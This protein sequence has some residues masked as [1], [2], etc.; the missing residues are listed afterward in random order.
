MWKQL[1]PLK[2]A[3]LAVVILSALFLPAAAEKVEYAVNVHDSGLLK[4]D[5]K[6]VFVGE[7][8]HIIKITNPTNRGATGV[9]LYVPIV[10]NE[11][12]RHYTILYSVKPTSEYT[13][14]V[15]GS[16]NIY[17]CWTNLMI[18]PRQTFTVELNY[19]LLSFSLTYTV[20]SNRIGSYNKNSELYI[21]Y[22]QPEE[23]IQSSHEEIVEKAQEITQG[24]EDP[25]M[26]A[27][28]IYNFVVS[29][30]RYEIQEEEKGALW[31]LENGKGDCS[32]YS[33]L[34]VALCRAAG[35][36]ARVQAGFAFH[37]AGQVLEDG[38][39]WAEYYLENYGW[40]PVDAT[41][42]LFNAMD[43]KHFSSIRS[44]PEAI[45][46]ANYHINSTDTTM[47]LDEQTVQLTNLQQS[48]FSENVFAKNITT[49]VQRIKQAET[50]ISIGK[51][52]GASVIFPSETREVEQQLLNAKIHV[53]NAIDTWETSTQIAGSNASLALEN[54]EKALYT[55]W[56][57]ILKVFVLYLG[58]LGASML[59]LLV[60]IRRSKKSL[61]ER[62]G[63]SHIATNYL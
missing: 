3:V 26:K 17:V 49:V 55:I 34:F 13:L 50:A 21:K 18:Q 27:H 48:A 42:R 60:F 11:T 22:I 43:N 56:M 39:M 23:L 29:Y 7:L 10:R 44:I 4:Y 31:A 36:P 12:A 6:E 46:Y 1:K 38:H 15:D 2:L 58:I 40:I 57:L 19:R 30:L 59:V 53:Q 37:Y 24:V 25:Y 45:P 32:E 16:G 35:I 33:Y 51:I 5:V 41:W 14:L 52:L 8:R 61:S 28:L 9:N 54:A 62:V 47:L 63:T 20:N